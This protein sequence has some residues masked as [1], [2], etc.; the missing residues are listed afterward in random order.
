MRRP[1][2]N[3]GYSSFGIPP[4]RAVPVTTTLTVAV[5]V[6]S[7]LGA[8]LQNRTGYGLALLR[9]DVAALFAGE[10]WR[11]LTFPFVESTF[12]GLLLSLLF[13]WMFGGWFESTYGGR[14][15]VRF[16]ALSNLGA[17]LLA[18]PLVFLVNFVGLF[19][20]PG[21]AEG[22]NA[23]L[24]AILVAMA[25]R[26]PDAQVLFFIFPMRA[27]TM[28]YIIIGIQVIQGIQTGMA[29]LSMTLGG[30]AMGYLLTT[31]NWRPGR[32]LDRIRLGWMKRRRRGI[33]VVPPRDNRWN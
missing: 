25:L 13:L 2:Y 8:L 11:L 20:D 31:G 26:A 27:R 28:V 24:N 18:I 5:L 15:L 4:A 10:L 19:A 6:V 29:G 23:A 33:Y 16:F 32:L 1:N 22:P 9:Y 30:V 17:G 12:W 14:N 21:I 3:T 7:L